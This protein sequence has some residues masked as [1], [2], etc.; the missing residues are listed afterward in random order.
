[1][2]DQYRFSFGPWNISSGADPF[3][4]PSRKEVAMAEKF[5]LYRE[6]GFEGIQLHDDD[7]V[8]LADLE[9]AYADLAAQDVSMVVVDYAHLIDVPGS[10]LY[11]KSRKVAMKIKGLS[12]RYRVVT[13]AA[14]QLTRRRGA[15]R[16]GDDA[17]KDR[18]PQLEDIA[19]G[20][21]W[22][23]TASQVLLIDHTKT[24]YI[25]ATRTRVM[26][27]V[28]PKN[29]HSERGWKLEIAW[30]LDTMIMTEQ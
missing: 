25:P 17:P 14:S 20:S 10:D 11:E 12:K 18:S 26:T 1:M 16:P 8:T 6:L 22:E 19:E 7:A 27:L 28:C 21:P 13:V 4:P 29:R 9:K 30:D 15:A 23:R 5:K 24:R 3:G 2:S